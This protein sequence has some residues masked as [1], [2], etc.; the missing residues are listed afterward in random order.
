MNLEPSLQCDPDHNTVGPLEVCTTTT[1]VNL[2]PLFT[3][4]AA[5]RMNAAA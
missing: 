4:D 2:H 1:I 3:W 5:Q